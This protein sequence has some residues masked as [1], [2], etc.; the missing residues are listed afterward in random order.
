MGNVEFFW[1]Y[2][3]NEQRPPWLYTFAHAIPLS[4]TAFSLKSFP[5]LPPSPYHTVITSSKKPS[6]ISNAENVCFLCILII[7]KGHV[8]HSM[9]T[10]M[11][12][13]FSVFPTGLWAPKD[14]KCTSFTTESPIPGA[15]VETFWVLKNSLLVWICWIKFAG[16]AADNL[17]RLETK[18]IPHNSLNLAP[19]ISL[20]SPNLLCMIYHQSNL[21]K[22]F[23]LISQGHNKS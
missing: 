5:G 19:I 3:Q 9:Y 18:P 17:P 14:G 2:R 12:I 10:I 16:A 20:L 8:Y 4:E 6:Q 21:L 1:L 7:F 15:R 11:L 13:Y 22:C 23:F